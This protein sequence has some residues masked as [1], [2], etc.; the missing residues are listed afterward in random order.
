L[1]VVSGGRGWRPYAYGSFAAFVAGVEAGTSLSVVVWVAADVVSAD[2]L[3]V[4]SHAYGPGAVRRMLEATV[5]QAPGGPRI[6]EW[7]DVR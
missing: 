3:I 7:R 4:R 2:T 5:Q 6:L 1:E